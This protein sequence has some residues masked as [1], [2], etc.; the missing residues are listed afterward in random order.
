MLDMVLETLLL[1]VEQVEAQVEAA[2]GLRKTAVVPINKAVLVMMAVVL[3]KTVLALELH[4]SWVLQHDLS[5]RGVTLGGTS[6]YFFAHHS[7]LVLTVP[8]PGRE[9]VL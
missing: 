6:K 5:A 3:M 2:V 7:L 4:V 8:L 9:L 1:A